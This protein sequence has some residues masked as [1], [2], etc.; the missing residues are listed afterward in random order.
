[1]YVL[2]AMSTTTVYCVPWAGHVTI[3]ILPDD[4]LLLIFRFDRLVF[5]D[6][7]CPDPLWDPPWRWHRLIHVCRRWRSLVFAS[8]NYLDLRLFCG[9]KTNL[10]LMGI[11]PPLPVIVRNI[12]FF[13]IL[14]DHDSDAGIVHHNRVY[15][16]KLLITGPGLKRLAL[17]M[18]EQFPALVHLVLYFVHIDSR[19]P[20]P[21]L[22]DRLLGGS[23][24]RLQ[25][26]KT[27]SIS[28]P[29]LPKLLLSATH[30]VHLDLRAIPQSGYMSP[31]AFVTGLAASANLEFIRIEFR[32]SRSLPYRESRCQPPPMRAVLPTL[33]RIELIGAS[34]WLED[35]VARIDVPLLDSTWISFF[36]QPIFD[37]PQ[38]SRF[39]RRTAKFQ[40]LK[41]AHVDVGYDRVHVGSLRPTQKHNNS[42]GFG[43][44]CR[45]MDRQVSS[46]V[47]V[48]TSFFPSIYVV[49]DLYIHGAEDLYIYGAEFSLQQWQDGTED[50]RWLEIFHLFTGVKNLYVFKEFAQ[51]ISPALLEVEERVGDVLPTLECLFVENLEPSGPVWEDLGQFVAARQLLCRPVTVSR[52]D[53]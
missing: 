50:A 25:S 18:Q 15:E 45:G 53:R 52:W 32:S 48:I 29:A 19:H 6:G 23:A 36:H 41:E 34:E 44:S 9:L 10:K 35:V 33:T 16:I 24:P 3:S 40:A 13:S 49:E 43:I 14:K 46:L 1:M 4:V 42:S 5:L 12:M 39:L 30:L 2:C 51:R 28:F 26:L 37:I 31:E 8:P 22:P 7:L 20:N 38:V 47:Q 17:A 11:W 21:T 27:H